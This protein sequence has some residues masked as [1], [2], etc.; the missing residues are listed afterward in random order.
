[1]RDGCHVNSSNPAV[2]TLL[3]MGITKNSSILAAGGDRLRSLS[4]IEYGLTDTGQTADSLLVVAAPLLDSL[5]LS[6]SSLLLDQEG[7]EQPPDDMRCTV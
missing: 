5:L 3:N 4:G 1:M 6:S 7:M 2:Q